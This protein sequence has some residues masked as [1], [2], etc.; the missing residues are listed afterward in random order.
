LVDEL[1]GF[2]GHVKT[3]CQGT[4]GIGKSSRT[5]RV[6]VP[7]NCPIREVHPDIGSDLER[8]RFRGA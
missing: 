8:R 6:D 5:S 3:M 2:A 1:D 7:G 4:S